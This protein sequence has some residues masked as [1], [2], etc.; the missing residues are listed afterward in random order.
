MNLLIFGE[1]RFTLETEP[2]AVQY[3][4]SLERKISVWSIPLRRVLCFIS[5][6][7]KIH[8]LHKAAPPASLSVYISGE[9]EQIR[10]VRFCIWPFQAKRQYLAL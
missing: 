3:A 6:C 10:I 2:T 7:Q 4:I 1:S 8:G 5:L 9:C